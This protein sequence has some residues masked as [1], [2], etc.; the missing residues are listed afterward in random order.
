MVNIR[1]LDIKKVNLLNRN[2]ILAGKRGTGKSILEKDLLYKQ[3]VHFHQPKRALFASPTADSTDEFKKI[4]NNECVTDKFDPAQLRELIDLQK[5]DSSVFN[6]LV[7]LDDCMYDK[8]SAK[9]VEFRDLIMNGRHYNIGLW[10]EMQYIM[11]M[12]PDIRSNVDYVFAFRDSSRNTRE[13]LWK[14]FFGIFPTYEEFS[15]VFDA[16]TQNYGCMVIDNTK[17]ANGIEDC[18]FWYKADANVPEFFMDC[19]SIPSMKTK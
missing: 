5:R 8:K 14:Y 17:P 9:S 4:V 3:Y 6:A 18:V 19:E 7:L 10:N 1:K 2:I 12:S 11:D 13:K 16:C 15:E